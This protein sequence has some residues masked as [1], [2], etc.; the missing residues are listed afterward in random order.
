MNNGNLKPYRSV[1]EARE[2]GK[3]GGK[4][5][6]AVRRKKRSFKEAAKWALNLPLS[7]T[8]PVREIFQDIDRIDEKDMTQLSGVMVAIIQKAKNG[9]VRAAEFLSDLL[10]ESAET[11]VAESSKTVIYIPNNDRGDT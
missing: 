10:Q 11:S 9:D 8:D 6:G 7:K 4:Q 1:N 5:S 2:N 3:K